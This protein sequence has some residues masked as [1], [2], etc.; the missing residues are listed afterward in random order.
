MSLPPSPVPVELP[1]PLQPTAKSSATLNVSPGVSTASSYGRA[2][3]IRGRIRP[4]FIIANFAGAQND[5]A[6]RM[7]DI[8]DQV[9]HATAS[10]HGVL[11]IPPLLGLARERGIDEDMVLRKAGIARELL[12]DPHADVPVEQVHAMVQALLDHTGDAALGLDAGR[13]YHPETFGLLGAVAALTPTV[14]EVIRLF[15]QYSHL[16]FTFFLLEFEEGARDGRLVFVEDGDLG[17]LRRFYLDREFAF[18]AETARTFW[19]D[20]YRQ[21]L[22]SCDFDYAEPAEA[23]RYRSL[24]PCDVRFGAA[25]AAI[26]GDF[27]SD[28]PRADTNALGVDLLKEHLNSFAGTQPDSVDVVDRVRRE[29]AVAVTARRVLPD[30]AR[31]A[32]GVGLSERVLRRRLAAH[33]TSFRALTDEVVAPLAKRYLRDTALSI[34]DV[35][36]R[37]GYSEPASF[38]RA[39]RRWTGTTPDVFRARR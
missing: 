33:G 8:I 2:T 9:P 14:R 10:R 25:T 1:L 19:P 15:V 37:V 22:R 18:V 13:H 16:T 28:R 3:V 7:L 5:R 6:G 4:I 20:N 38:T 26:A 30:V 24:F 17:A 27:T 39:F 34:A 36:D 32:A 12:D 11:G 31:V 29:I 23:A 35:A 21:I